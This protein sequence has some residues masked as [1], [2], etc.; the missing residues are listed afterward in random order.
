M[1]RV[2]CGLFLLISLATHGLPI[3]IATA[4]EE[5]PPGWDVEKEGAGEAPDGEFPALS[6]SERVRYKTV[7]RVLVE[8]IN[9]GDV[10][11]YRQLFSDAGWD[12]ASQWWRDMFALQKEKFGLIEKAYEPRRGYIQVGKLAYLGEVTDGATMLVTFEESKGGALNFQLD[13]SGKIIQTDVFIHTSFTLTE[14]EEALLIYSLKD[15]T[16]GPKE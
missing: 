4:Q 10:E 2:L 16:R 15:S 14:P 11:T 6:D 8:A 7:A 3:A 5:T 12:S 9:T 1:A 13:D